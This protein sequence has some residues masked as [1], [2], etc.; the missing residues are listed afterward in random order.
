MNRK[1]LLAQCQEWHKQNE[2]QKIIDTLEAIPERKRTRET[3]M[4][5]ARAYNNLADDEELDWSDSR[6]MLRR[7]IELMSPY[8]D[9]LSED[10]TWNFEMGFAHLFLEQEGSALWYLEDALRLYPG[11]DFGL[12]SREVIEGLIN[13]S[14]AGLALPDFQKLYS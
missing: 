12:S 4:E 8:E 10:Y 3:D 13:G 9:E 11:D 5:L 6:I 1:E 2:H 14:K 7:A